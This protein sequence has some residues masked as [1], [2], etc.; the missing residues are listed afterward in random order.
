MNHSLHLVGDC[1]AVFTTSEVK[2]AHFED[3]VCFVLDASDSGAKG[4]SL[5]FWLH[6]ILEDGSQTGGWHIMGGSHEAGC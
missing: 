6:A 3:P 2:F 4:K 5:E 1:F